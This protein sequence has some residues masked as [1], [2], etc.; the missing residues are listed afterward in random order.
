MRIEEALEEYLLQLE[1]DGR[2]HHTRDQYRRH[3]G[4]LARWLAVEGHRLDVDAIDH[5]TVARFLTSDVVR[6][7]AD[8]QPRKA[9]SANCVRSSM[10][11]FFG[12]LDAA[13]HVQVNAARLVRRARCSP[14]PPR[15]LSEAEQARLVAALDEAET[16]AERRDR[17]LFRAML[18]TGARISEMLE[19]RIEDLDLEE[20]ELRLR[21]VKGGC[22]DVLLLPAS[23]AQILAEHLDQRRSGWLFE[24][25]G[26]RPLTPRQAARRLEGWLE[27][28]DVR[29][30]ASLHSLR[31]SF[32]TDLYQRTGD[33]L[34]VREALRH[35]SITSTV[36]YARC[37]GGR[38]REAVMQT[39]PQ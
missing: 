22:E 26:T 3:V 12:F 11:S 27:R 16:E 28:A 36:I 20:G 37:D 10:K 8:G 25:Q 7:R 13:G 38:L 9:T 39:T 21:K 33:L 24:G 15:A 5:R 29:R 19:A 2:S 6:L 4:M 31:H 1:A 30:A 35:R 34:L 18:A 14:G 23:V 17:V 32:A